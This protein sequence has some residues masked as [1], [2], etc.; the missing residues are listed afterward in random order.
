MRRMSLV[1]A[2]A[3]MLVA[4]AVPA[5]AGAHTWTAWAG[6]PGK[7]PAGTPKHAEL[8][9]FFPATLRIRQGDSVRFRNNE[10]HTA[11]FLAKGQ[12]APAL[13]LPDPGG[14]KYSGINDSAGNPFFFNGNPKFIYNPAAFGPVGSTTVGDGKE[15][16]SGAFG[17]GAGR[18]SVTFKF[19]KRGVY[20]VICLIHPG[21]RGRIIVG[22]KKSGVAGNALVQAQVA[23]QAR[24][25]YASVTKASKKTPPANTVYAGIGDKAT[26]LGFLPNR[27]TVKAGTAV[28]FIERSSSE[29]HNMVFGPKDYTDQFFKQTDLLPQGPGTPNQV[30]PVDVYGSDPPSNGAYTYDGANHGNGFFVTPLMDKQSASPLPSTERVTFTQPGTYHYYCAIHGPEMSGD[31]VVTQ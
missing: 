24:Q 28:D 5:A 30:T 11:T 13:F 4:L 21:M 18:S 27:L 9:L 10:F 14:A 23:S 1:I 8:N 22:S 19:A 3:A 7:A 12:K 17:K 6:S 16:S 2:A 20:T 31:I 25:Q 26:L 29:V 15:H